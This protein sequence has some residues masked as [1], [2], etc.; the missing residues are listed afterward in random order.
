[1]PASTLADEPS[2][3]AE[4]SVESSASLEPWSL[5]AELP[6]SPDGLSDPSAG[7]PAESGEPAT[8]T[9]SWPKVLA[10]IA[11]GCIIDSQH[12]KP[13]RKAA[14]ILLDRSI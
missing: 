6:L 12:S 14:I 10:Y 2:A 8:E 1:M 13:A 7:S 11:S 9:S 4:S 3:L 5:G